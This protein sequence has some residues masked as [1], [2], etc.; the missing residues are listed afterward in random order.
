MVKVHFLDGK[1]AGLRAFR[2]LLRLDIAHRCHSDDQNEGDDMLESFHL[3][4][5]VCF[6][7]ITIPITAMHT[8]ETATIAGRHLAAKY[9][10]NNDDGVIIHRPAGV[11]L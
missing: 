4:S 1:L 2:S 8:M 7:S 5:T 9:F 10:Q 3:F 11:R 6:Q